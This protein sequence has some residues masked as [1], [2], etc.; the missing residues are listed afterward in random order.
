[1]DEKE[2]IYKYDDVMDSIA[3]MVGRKTTFLT[4]LSQA[5]HK[6]LGDKFMGVFPSDKIPRLTETTPYCILNLDNSN[7]PGSHWVAI[8]RLDDEHAMMYDS[9]GRPSKEI[10]P[11]LKKSD[12]GLIIDTDYDAEQ[13]T[14]Q[15]DCG[16][17]SLAWLAFLHEYGPEAAVL[18]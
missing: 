15:T 9:F 6:L 16:L 10:F 11:A 7:Q 13:S 12:N 14:K 5:G 2:A 1:M 18:I 17:R 4:D 3:P 8:A